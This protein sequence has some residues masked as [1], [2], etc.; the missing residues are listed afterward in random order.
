MFKSKYYV[1]HNLGS[2]AVL[3]IDPR[4]VEFY[5]GTHSPTS[6]AIRKKIETV[7]ENHPAWRGSLNVIKRSIP[8][9][10]FSFLIP[11]KYYRKKRLISEM[12]QHRHMV[13][14][15]KC[16]DDVSKSSWYRDLFRQL[17]TS[18]TANH[19]TIKM[20]SRDDI[21]SFFQGYVLD[22]VESLEKHGYDPSKSHEHGTALIGAEGDIHKTYKG[23]H[24]FSAARILGVRNVPILVYGVHEE[25]FRTRIGGR[26]DIAALR[27]ELRSLQDRYA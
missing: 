20:R 27:R 23:N 22:L 26:M 18:G 15:L 5:L 7:A 12:E 19:K 16:R 3:W 14:F 4:K 10:D 1:H 25:W 21:M 6:A 17:E 8:R 11:E 24:R 9:Q 2:A 13:D